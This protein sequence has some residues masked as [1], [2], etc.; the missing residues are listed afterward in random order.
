MPTFGYTVHLLRAN[1]PDRPKQLHRMN[2]VGEDE[3]PIARFWR[4]SGT[5]T[6]PSLAQVR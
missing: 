4:E 1:T 2:A 3:E 6:S 5:H